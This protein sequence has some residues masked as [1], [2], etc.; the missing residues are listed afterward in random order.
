MEAIDRTDFDAVGQFAFDTGFGNNECH[1][2]NPAEKSAA[3]LFHV[4]RQIK[5]AD[6]ELVFE[7]AIMDNIEFAS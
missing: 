6:T 5:P 4:C 1:V 7:G 2:I 3:T